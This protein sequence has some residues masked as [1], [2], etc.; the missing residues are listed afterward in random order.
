MFF[1]FCSKYDQEAIWLY[2]RVT[3]G[4]LIPA[5]ILFSEDLYDTSD[6]SLRLNDNQYHASVTLPD[7]SVIDNGHVKL[8]LNR[9]Q[10]LAHPFWN[11][12]DKIEKEYF[13]QEWNSFL[14]GWLKAFEPALVNPVAPGMLAGYDAWPLRWRVLAARA[15]LPIKRMHLD[16]E[17]DLVSLFSQPEIKDSLV[18]ALVY[19]NKLYAPTELGRF[20]EGCLK[21]SKMVNCP[22]LEVVFE[23][24]Q[25]RELLF[26][27]AS[28]MPSF[29]R[30]SYKFVE[31]FKLD[32]VGI[33]GEVCLT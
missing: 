8:F 23:R 29:S 4:N 33:A 9:V 13:H 19:K 30:H 27:S 24:T 1:L 31:S 2:N 25:D 26:V 10:G 20:A 18:S 22:L 7:G 11:R 14:T 6:W 32:L 21:L 5:H 12:L 3:S 17:T 15:G 16:S 28:S